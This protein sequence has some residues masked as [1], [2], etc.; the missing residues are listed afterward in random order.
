MLQP[1]SSSQS[2]NLALVTGCNILDNFNLPMVLI[3][4]DCEVTVRRYFLVTLGDGSWNVVGVQVSA[5]L[6]VDQT[7]NR[8][9]SNESWVGLWVVVGIKAVRVEPP[10]IVGIFVMVTC[11]LLLVGALGVS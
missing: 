11:N 7:N 4:T 6:G 3:V 8:A 2:A 1:E 5:R 10:V 9:V